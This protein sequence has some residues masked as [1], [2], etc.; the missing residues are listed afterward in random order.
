MAPIRAFVMAYTRHDQTK[1]RY[2]AGI[3]PRKSPAK[4]LKTAS[5]SQL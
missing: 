1:A 5:V 4:R 3:V 2:E